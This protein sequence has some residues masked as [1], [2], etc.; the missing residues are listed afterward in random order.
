MILKL[1]TL[2]EN[3]WEYMYYIVVWI[4]PDMTLLDIV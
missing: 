3:S 1:D 2:Y 4:L